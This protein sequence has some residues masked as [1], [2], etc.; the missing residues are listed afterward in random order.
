MPRINRETRKKQAQDFKDA[1]NNKKAESEGPNRKKWNIRDMAT[2]SCLTDG[3]AEFKAQFDKGKNISATGCAGTGKTHM[4]ISLGMRDILLPEPQVKQLIIVRSCVPTRDIGFLPGDSEEKMEAYE[5]PYGEMINDI[6]GS[7]MTYDFMKRA[8]L[9]RFVPTSFLRGVTWDNSIVIVDESQDM[10]F[11]E[12]SSIITRLGQN[13]RV[14]LAGD[15]K[16]DDLAHYNEV[17][18]LSKVN[19]IFGKMGSFSIIN[20]TS[21][22]I[23]RSGLVK[24][25]ILACEEF[26]TN[27]INLKLVGNKC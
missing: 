22:D 19:E 25:F 24:E 8:G 26:D 1:D 23:V 14:I 18:G 5:A 3:Q 13:S 21:D 9:I 10:T 15:T 27:K 6:F 16:Q 12:I 7:P 4:A 20:F 2:L 11:H 17:S